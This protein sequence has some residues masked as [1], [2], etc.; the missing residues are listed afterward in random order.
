MAEAVAR[1]ALESGAVN[2]AGRDVFVCSAGLA[3]WDGGPV[4]DETIAALER[5]G[6]EFDGHSKRLTA[7][8]IRKAQVVLGMTRAHVMAAR[9]LVAGEQHQEKVQLLDPAGD[10][11]DPI[12]MTQNA[13][14]A[15]ADRMTRVI[16]GRLSQLL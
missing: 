3:A 15:L 13:Y 16:P 6:I 2:G 11:E 9:A 1:H 12:G 8:M 10:V 4:S 14:D 5:L 7:E